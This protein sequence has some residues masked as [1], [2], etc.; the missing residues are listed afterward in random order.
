MSEKIV[1]VT[2]GS[3]G[4]GKICSEYLSKSNYIVYGTT[5][6]KIK[7][8][9]IDNKI[10]RFTLIT[11]D[12]TKK[13]TIKEAIKYILGKHQKID[14]L[15]NNAGFGMAGST[16]DTSYEEVLMQFNVNFFGLINVTNSIL[17]IYRKQGYGQ[18]INIGSVAGYVSIPFQGIYS[19]CKAALLSYSKTLRNEIRPFNIKVTVIEPGDI[20]T[21]FSKNRVT[22]NNSN[23]QSVYIDRMRNSIKT[24]Y[25][26]SG[27]IIFLIL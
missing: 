22:S 10:N 12:V 25:Q 11:L 5:R 13:E 18:I 14:I 9:E 3:S 6:R 1:L 17:P 4:I 27:E 20:K 7:Y 21:G 19:S 26:V 15:V 24:K 23:S 2:G 8:D 16:E